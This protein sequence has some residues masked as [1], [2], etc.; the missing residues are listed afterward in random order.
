MSADFEAARQ[1]K[2]AE[3]RRTGRTWQW[4]D[5]VEH[6]KPARRKRMPVR[7][8]RYCRADGTSGT[9][10]PGLVMRLA[11]RVLRAL[12]GTPHTLRSGIVMTVEDGVLTF[13]APAR[14]K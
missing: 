12:A 3:I 7:E 1:R 5:P 4:P 2:I 11:I 13:T 14:P 6:R 8:V 9:L 10:R